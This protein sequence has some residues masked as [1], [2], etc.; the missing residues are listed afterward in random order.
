MH[1][2]RDREDGPGS[3]MLEEEV[4]RIWGKIEKMAQEWRHW[5]RRWSAAVE[6]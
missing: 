2:V 4:G 6:R 5:N 1:L 3:E